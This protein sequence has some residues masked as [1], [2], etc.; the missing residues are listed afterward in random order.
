MTKI[1]RL[2]PFALLLVCV[3]GTE[4][5]SAQGRGRGRG[6]GG[7]GGGGGD[8][9]PAVTISASISL[10]VGDRERITAFY[11]SSEPR[12]AE[13]LPP[14]IRR[15]LARGKPLP[16]GIA[17]R[18]VPDRLRTAVVLRPGFEIVEVGLD[19]FLVEVATGMVHDVLMDIVR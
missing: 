18:Q 13:A 2:V 14:G 4:A 5:A 12:G 3:L 6:G 17:K 7:G 9:E 10:S 16:P 19:V 8:P 11:A 1:P 15:N